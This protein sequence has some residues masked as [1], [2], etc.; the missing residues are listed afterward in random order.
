MGF[1]AKGPGRAQIALQSNRLADEAVVEKERVLWKKEI[2]K[3][4]GTLET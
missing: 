2:G 4:Q 3:L 1:Y